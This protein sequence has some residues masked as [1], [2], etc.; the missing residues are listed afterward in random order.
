MCVY[1]YY[2]G[3][4]RYVNYNSWEN[5][6]IIVGRQWTHESRDRSLDAILP[7]KRT[8]VVLYSKMEYI[9]GLTLVTHNLSSIYDLS[10]TIFAKDNSSLATAITHRFPYGNRYTLAVILMELGRSPNNHNLRS[11][12]DLSS[13]FYYYS[14]LFICGGPLTIVI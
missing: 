10:S 5:G 14:S 2:R 3:E 1:P 4:P 13:V 7:A 11:I 6:N 12:W 8:P 9:Q